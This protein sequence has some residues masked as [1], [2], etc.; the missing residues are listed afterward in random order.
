MIFNNYTNY[1]KQM[2]SEKQFSSFKKQTILSKR[3]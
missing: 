2:N 3:L 1:L